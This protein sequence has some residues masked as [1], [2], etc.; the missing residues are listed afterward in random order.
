MT[1]SEFNDMLRE[2]ARKLAMGEVKEIILPLGYIELNVPNA[3]KITKSYIRNTIS[4]VKEVQAIG[5]IKMRSFIDE[6]RGDCYRFTI[7]HFTEVDRANKDQMAIVKRAA[8]LSALRPLMQ[9]QPIMTDIENEHLLV[10]Q[11]VVDRFH[12]IIK[13]KIDSLA[14]DE[15]AEE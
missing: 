8:K 2:S 13:A 6:E 1:N 7:E 9:I 11:L 5:R 15:D 12:Q 14:G 4:R 10:A 3:K